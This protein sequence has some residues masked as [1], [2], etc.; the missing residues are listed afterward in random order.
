MKI[1]R[2]IWDENN[3]QHLWHSHQVSPEEVFEAVFGPPY[4][5]ADITTERDGDYIVIY[6]ATASGR[7]LK[8]VGD[9]VG[10]GL[11]IFSA[12]DMSKREKRA[13]RSR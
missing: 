3:V 13:Y 11:R 6:G 7:L 12:R 2:L 4:E 5:D 9:R 1:G 10:D 8:L